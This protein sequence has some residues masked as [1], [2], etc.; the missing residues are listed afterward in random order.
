MTLNLVDALERDDWPA[1]AACIDFGIETRDHLRALQYAVGSDGVRTD[2]LDAALGKGTEIQ[3]LISPG[4]P[5][6]FVTFRTLW[7]ELPVEPS[8]L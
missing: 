2:E 6:R 7:D 3:R 8:D 5:Y 4:N 1:P